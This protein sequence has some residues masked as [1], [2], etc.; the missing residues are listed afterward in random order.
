MPSGPLLVWLATCR[1]PVPV[2][3][4][5]R[6][7]VGNGLARLSLC[8]GLITGAVGCGGRGEQVEGR[9]GD[10]IDIHKICEFLGHAHKV[11]C[12][13]LMPFKLGAKPVAEVAVPQPRLDLDQLLA[14]L[15]NV[16][17]GAAHQALDLSGA[18]LHDDP[19]LGVEGGVVE[20]GELGGLRAHQKLHQLREL[21][22]C[23]QRPQ[24]PREP[25]YVVYRHALRLPAEACLDH[26]LVWAQLTRQHPRV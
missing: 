20:E 21:L 7:A 12:R 23:Q 18:L 3:K 9:G 8:Q 11:G 14:D 19:S 24:P 5:A 6:G 4:L 10:L 13:V 1:R 2:H 15:D 22:W 17:S 16:L 25:P 26:R